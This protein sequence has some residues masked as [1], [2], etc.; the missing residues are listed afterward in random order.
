MP[1]DQARRLV[2]RD[3]KDNTRSKAVHANSPLAATEPSP[4]YQP[5]TI[6]GLAI[7]FVPLETTATSS[8]SPQPQSTPVVNSEGDYTPFSPA[9]L[10][11]TS[12]SGDAKA[13]TSPTPALSSGSSSSTR[14]PQG[15]RSG[16][17]RP[18]ARCR[19]KK[20]KCD[21]MKPRCS[22]CEK[23]G[24]D[25]TCVYD[26]DESTIGASSSMPQS[27]P[28][29]I[30][31]SSAPTTSMPSSPT[32]TATPEQPS[33]KEA[34]T[35]RKSGAQDASS[36][37]SSPLS[38]LK[39]KGTG[40]TPTGNDNSN[41]TNTNTTS[42]SPKATGNGHSSRSNDKVKKATAGF[43]NT[44]L[45]SDETITSSSANSPALST[46][47]RGLES[48]EPPQK[49]IKT[50]SGSIENN[51]AALKSSPL[52]AT[53]TSRTASQPKPNSSSGSKK[54]SQPSEEAV[55]IETIEDGVVSELSVA[56]ASKDVKMEDATEMNDDSKKLNGHPDATQAA[57]SGA[58]TSR[59]KKQ[60]K[61]ITTSTGGG[62]S[63]RI[64][65]DLPTSKPPPPFVIDK[66]Q[67][68]RKW[69]RSSGVFQTLGGELSLP[70]WTSDQEML[71]NEP[72][73]FF[74][75]RTYN[76]NTTPGTVGNSSTATNLARIAVLNQMD[77]G[78]YNYDTPERGSTPESGDSSPAPQPALPS[79]KKKM[80][81][82]Q[83]GIRKSQGTEGNANGIGGD[84]GKTA[85]IRAGLEAMQV[86]D[87]PVP[88]VISRTHTG[89]MPLK[90]KG[91]AKITGDEDAENSSAR[92]T[93]GPSTVAP[94]TTSKPR[95]I[96]TRPRTFPCSFEGCTKSFMDKFH[97]KRHEKRHV[98]QVITCGVDGCT[99][100][101]DSISTMRRHQSMMHRQWKEEMEAAAAAAAA[102]AYAAR[103]K[104]RI[105]GDDDE[106]G[107]GE[108]GE[109]DDGADGGVEGGDESM[110]SSPTLSATPFT[111]AS[112]PI[113]EQI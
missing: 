38:I 45:P 88:S 72:R 99:K 14:G 51:V 60:A 5:S 96:P 59:S 82:P 92:S 102:S 37:S 76:L 75:Q 103:E 55:D 8:T 107:E 44:A 78:L 87:H 58:G 27:S 9:M 35:N 33:R 65:V 98:T 63:S 29:L 109:D 69:G 19:V 39:N 100:A 48:V 25:A 80:K 68:A 94:T 49:K 43:P 79:K 46:S 28:N 4:K 54:S 105:D 13:E 57:S 30:Q 24:S 112:S 89:K 61:G 93:P 16:V 73:P 12:T 71:L 6:S 36:L 95:P 53:V 113:R 32:T 17:Y 108:G 111:A 77:S 26:N 67:K 1:G 64:M 85:G 50:G 86:D 84:S 110:P 7:G 70:F 2:D 10:I 74:V 83:R 34:S 3:H 23:A 66:N 101:Y 56:D 31:S 42:N 91:T 20:T 97:L 62:P 106:G 81:V 18:C 40:A 47:N 22:S 52:R 90:R 21:R 104:A 15:P 41:N 11:S